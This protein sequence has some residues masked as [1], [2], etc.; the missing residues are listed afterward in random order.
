MAP[1][2]SAPLLGPSPASPDAEI[3]VRSLATLQKV[4]AIAGGDLKLPQ[5]CVVGD[6]SSGKSSLLSEIT[7]VK[8]PT[9]SG[10]CT[11]A[12]IVV[13]CRKVDKD[14]STSAGERVFE[15]KQAEGWQKCTLEELPTKILHKQTTTLEEL[16]T[17]VCEEEILEIE[18]KKPVLRFAKKEIFVRVSGPDVLD[19]IV[20]DLPGIIHSGEGGAEVKDMINKYCENQQTLILLVSEAKAD[21]EN[22]AA[23]DLARKHDPEGFRTLRVLTKFDT[24]DSENT[25][26]RAIKFVKEGLRRTSSF[27][28]TCE[29]GDTDG[30]SASEGEGS[31]TPLLTS[32]L[33][34]HAVICSSGG[35]GYSEG[36]EAQILHAE[37]GLPESRAGIPA[38][39]DRLP[40]IY[41]ALIRNNIDGVMQQ[42]QDKKHEARQELTQIGEKAPSIAGVIHKAQRFLTGLQVN[43]EEKNAFKPPVFQGETAVERCMKEIVEKWWTPTLKLFRKEVEKLTER[44]MDL[45]MLAEK[46]SNTSKSCSFPKSLGKEI[47][48]AWKC[49]CAAELFPVLRQKLAERL[50]REIKWGTVNYDFGISHHRESICPEDFTNEMLKLLP[51]K[52]FP[53]NK[54]ASSLDNRNTDDRLLVLDA[55]ILKEM[56]KTAREVVVA[57]YDMMD[58]HERQEQEVLRVVKAL[59]QVEHK[60]I[61]D[62]A[63]KEVVNEILQ[64]R[65]DWI[66]RELIAQNE[67]LCKAA[68][69]DK[70]VQQRR[71]QLVAKLKKMEECEKELE[72]I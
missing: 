55:A 44:S 42:V 59:W 43:F 29:P 32:E 35:K 57:R 12:P 72:K 23:N 51:D 20:I 61:T 31:E 25:T 4:R 3:Y 62:A 40:A 2:T 70:T 66:P 38:L 33:G 46:E 48:R 11:K 24:F 68:E 58:L 10:T 50:H 56:I 67:A 9:A 41:A 69:E 63:M 65:K 39:R 71:K 7:G 8:F 1:S 5:I 54:K 27:A 53:Y 30:E 45:E 37:L 52:G 18:N 36:S 28:S 26:E 21:Y 49:Y 15:I 13:E 47:H 64:K 34:P 16:K 22:V 60:T 19:L 17:K 6:Q 14:S